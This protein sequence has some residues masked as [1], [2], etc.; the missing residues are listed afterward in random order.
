MN[1]TRPY[2]AVVDVEQNA[3]VVYVQRRLDGKVDVC[4]HG[5]KETR[6]FVAKMDV[7]L[8][9]ALV[10]DN[11]ASQLRSTR[12]ALISNIISASCWAEYDEKTEPQLVE[13]VTK[14]LQ[15]MSIIETIQ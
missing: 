15:L 3:A 5:V 2:V 12:M 4:I 1:K 13:R 11:I 9:N 8:L 7:C 6:I 10:M 14:L